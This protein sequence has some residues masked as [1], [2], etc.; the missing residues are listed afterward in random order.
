[1]NV[2]LDT[3]FLTIP[4]EKKID[5][6]EEIKKKLPQAHFVILKSIK[7]ELKKLNTKASDVAL[8]LIKRKKVKIVELNK[9]QGLETTDDEIVEYGKRNKAFVATNDKELKERCLKKNI[10][11]IYLRSEKT[12]EIRR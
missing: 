12:I 2:L 5:I 3:N 6:F 9:K 10:P 11:V 7:K 8:Q 4:E 1:M